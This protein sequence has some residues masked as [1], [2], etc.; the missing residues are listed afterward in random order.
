MRL[1]F[2]L[3]RKREFSLGEAQRG[4]EEVP[5][6]VLCPAFSVTRVVALELLVKPFVYVTFFFICYFH[7]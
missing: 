3:S 1:L 4:R 5:G 7:N 6:S 2:I